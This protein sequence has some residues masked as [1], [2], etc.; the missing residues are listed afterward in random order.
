MF[1]Q[2]GGEED[3]ED[4]PFCQEVSGIVE[5]NIFKFLPLVPVLFPTYLQVGVK[6]LH[7]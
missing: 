7:I 4:H 1:K 5:T 6:E 3:I 2:G